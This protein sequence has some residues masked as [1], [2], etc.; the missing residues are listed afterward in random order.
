MSHLYP[1]LRFLGW[2]RSLW[3]SFLGLELASLTLKYQTRVEVSDSDNP[4][5]LQRFIMMSVKSFMG[6]DPSLNHR[7]GIEVDP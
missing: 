7:Q 2:I 4:T 3:C 5:S 6:F 1:N